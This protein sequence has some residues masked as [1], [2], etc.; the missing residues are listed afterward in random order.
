LSDKSR[1][2]SRRAAQFR[3]GADR[4]P[5][6]IRP[7]QELA[8]ADDIEEFRITEPTLL[9]N[10]DAPR[11]YDPAAETKNRY[12]QKSFGD[13]AERRTSGLPQ[14]EN[15]RHE[16][17]VFLPVMQVGIMRVLV[18][19]TAMAVGMAVRFAIRIR[20]PMLVPMMRVVDM[21]VLV[22]EWFVHMLVF[23][24][25]GKVQIHAH[26]HEPGSADQ[27]PCDGLA[28]QRNRDRSADKG[29]GRKI[30][31]GPGRTE[32]AQSEHKECQANAVT[33]ETDDSGRGKR[34]RLGQLRAMHKAERSIDGPG[35]NALNRFDLDR[36]GAAEL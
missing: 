29:G 6:D 22:K 34:P 7:R 30:R 20:R 26:R 8:Q 36:I 10:G 5:N 27:G 12:G 13:G 18:D 24:F 31:P 9:V 3:A 15:G 32:M 28:E 19:E 33:E 4:D 35:G 14:R 23:M 2:R 25:F 17:S 11:P 1:G 21:P 16:L